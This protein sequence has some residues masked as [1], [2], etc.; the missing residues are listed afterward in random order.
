MIIIM[1]GI[2][3]YLKLFQNDKK[4]E[5]KKLFAASWNYVCKVFVVLSHILQ[6]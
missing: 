4:W 3:V 1:D 2:D 6:C 5:E